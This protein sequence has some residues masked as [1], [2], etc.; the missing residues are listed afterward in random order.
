MIRNAFT[1]ALFLGV[2]ASA[3]LAAA[4]FGGGGFAL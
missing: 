3:L 1:Y 2:L 4:A